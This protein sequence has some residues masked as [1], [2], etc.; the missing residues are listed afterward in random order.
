[1]KSIPWL[2]WIAV[3]GNLAY[4]GTGLDAYRQG[5]YSLA[6]TILHRNTSEQDPQANYYLGRMRLYGY[7][8]L[9]N[10]RLAFRYFEQAGDKG[11]LDAQLLLARYY[12]LSRDWAK[13]LY[14]FKKAADAGDLKAQMYCAAAYMFGL[15]CTKNEDI[16]R[17]Y[18]IEAAK[19]GNAI[20]QYTLSEYFLG[21]R[22]GKNKKLGLIWLNKAVEQGDFKAKLK[23]A[24]LYLTAKSAA[25]D[26]GKAKELLQQLAQSNYF[27]AVRKLGD[28]AVYKGEEEEAKNYYLKAAAANDASAA[29][30]LAKLYLNSQ[31]RFYNLETGFM[32]VLQA[33]RNDSLEAQNMLASMYKEG[34]G[35]KADEVLAKEWQEKAVETA[36]KSPD[37]AL[38][39]SKWLTEDRVD[40]F[41]VNGYRLG[42]IYQTW[43][44]PLALKENNYNIAPQTQ[45]LTR[46]ELYQPKFFM[47]KPNEIGINEYFE[48]IAANLNRKKTELIFTHYPLP[49]QMEA[50]GQTES[51]ALKHPASFNFI[52]ENYP[53]PLSN[54]LKPF[55]YIEE[56][57][58]GW[59]HQA[60]LQVV[61]SDLYNKAILGESAAQFEL[62][63]LYHYGIAVAKNIPQA[64]IYYQLAAMQQHVQAEYNLAILYLEGKTNPIDYYQGI[65][66]LTDAAFKGNVY[67]QYTLA[68]IYEH[69]FKDPNGNTVIPPNPQQAIAM[70]YLASSNHYGPA[71]YNLAEYLVKQPQ[72]GLSVLSKQNR[73]KLI[74]R[75]Y[76][77]AVKEGIVEANLPLAFYYAMDKENKKREQA[78]AVAKRE[79]QRGNKYAALLLG[80]MYERGLAV[81]INQA[82]SL[83]WYHQAG[84]NPVNSFILGT[85]YVQGI[86][87]TKDIEKGR[88]LLQQAAAAN[89]P[90]AYL[91]LAVL[92]HQM[93]E[94]FLTDLDTS[95]QLGN[96]IA[97]LL[98]ADYYLAQ[99]N[100]ADKIKQAQEIYH[101]FAEKGDKEAQ[102]KLGFLYDQG[103]GG[104]LSGEKAAKWYL[105]A[106]EQGQSVAQ[107][108]LGRMY[109]LGKLDG[110]N[111]NY[112]EAKRWFSLSSLN[113]PRAALALGFIFETVEDDYSKAKEN[114]E[115]A[116]QKGNKFGLFNLALIYEE[117]KNIPVDY[118][119]AQLLY[120]KAA[121]LNHPQAMT[122]LADLY[123]NGLIE[124]KRNE[125]EAI[126][127]YKKAA[128]LGDSSALYQLGLLAETG[129][130]MKLDFT[131]AINYYQAAARLGHEKAKLALA[132]MYQFGLGTAKDSDKAY[133]L[134][135]DL[136]GENNAYAQYQM[137]LLHLD[138]A[139]GGK[140]QESKRLLERASANGSLQAR[141]T[142]Q[143]LDAEQR[144]STS[145]I[146][147]VVINP[148][149]PTNNHSANLMYFDAISEWNRGEEILSRSILHRIVKQFPHY[150]PAR[151]TYEQL[152][153]TILIKGMASSL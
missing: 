142:L 124:G 56:L 144:E 57:T 48:V 43:N 92:K 147:P 31:S 13:A 32:W 96:S 37:P 49:I 127:W 53:Y 133:T 77:G 54:E 17:R 18:Y 125:E 47:I 79:A 121:E 62:G 137:A 89:F 93:K 141:N 126:F 97:G 3:C 110:K 19:R 120:K 128:S 130:A 29:L 135:A 21:S 150:I 66:W 84:L 116:A 112:A 61:L 27:P 7:G 5:D 103:L 1:M 41:E 11:V 40:N 115:I 52:E 33:A 140:L 63:Q 6:A 99:T 149:P 20:A 94:E 4:A 145:F 8:V 16:A 45:A 100:E 42:G 122:K 72:R 123:F 102:L 64:I 153:Q 9:K 75:L 23:L 118:P 68:R 119:K 12:I 113:Y 59:E 91:N 129:V 152:S 15:G 83:Y 101:Y 44:N 109:Q 80:I 30:S 24:E 136:A 71:Q 95:R 151:K 76:E 132:R 108:L 82:A 55:N 51:L 22:D 73:M 98:L 117:G 86:G 134:Y 106:A 67:A 74:K 65:N 28:I 90:Y 81:P 58:R 105:S 34:K 88:S 35:V 107:Y 143:R 25:S 138:K 2:Y 50:L 69:G 26:E 139:E 78:F 60:N 39:A 70:Y 104:E 38:E 14:W 111:P 10:D 148:T 131:Q 85:Y 146:E 87:V 114:Y 46:E 36:N